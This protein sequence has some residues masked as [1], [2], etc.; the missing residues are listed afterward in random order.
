M[1]YLKKGRKLDVVLMIIFPFV[2]VI[3]SLATRAHFLYSIFLFYGLPS[4]WLTLRARHAALRAFLFSLLSIP[5]AFIIDYVALLDEAWETQYSLFPK[6][7]GPVSVE[8]VL[9]FF[10]SVYFVVIF[11]ERFLDHVRPAL[12]GKHIVHFILFIAVLILM[13]GA[14]FVI[15]SRFLLIPYAYLWIGIILILLPAV[16]VLSSFPRLITKLFKAGVY[17]FTFTLTYELVGLH[18][19]NWTFPGSRFIGWVELFTFRFPF[20]ELF[21]WMILS[22]FAI[23]AF[24]EYFDDDRR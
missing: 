15:Q 19:K 24:Y 23:L 4:M 13:F 1:F 20:E 22:A 21:F 18:L 17:F 14:T 5:F 11:Y 16:L 7:L 6:L 9:W 12:V 10:L 8:D 2:A 3:V